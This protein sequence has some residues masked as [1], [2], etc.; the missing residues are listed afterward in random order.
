MRAARRLA[1]ILIADV[2]VREHRDGTPEKRANGSSLTGVI[3]QGV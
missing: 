3:T 1:G 2:G